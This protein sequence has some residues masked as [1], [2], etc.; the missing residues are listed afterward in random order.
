M[1][2]TV[3]YVCRRKGIGALD[4][5]KVASHASF[6]K[7]KEKKPT[8]L[9]YAAFVNRILLHQILTARDRDPHDLVAELSLISKRY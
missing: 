2:G 4:V 9:I 7:E 8:K 5:A 1:C 6:C 3:N